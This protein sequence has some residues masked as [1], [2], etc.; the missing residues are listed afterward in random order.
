MPQ[1]TEKLPR[2][3]RL[4]RIQYKPFSPRTLPNWEGTAETHLSPDQRGRRTPRLPFPL[5]LVVRAGAECQRPTSPW[6]PKPD[7]SIHQGSPSA[8]HTLLSAHCSSSWCGVPQ[9]PP[10]LHHFG[11]RQPVRATG[12]QG[13]GPRPPQL[14]L[15][16]Q[17]TPA[18]STPDSPVCTCFSFSCPDSVFP[19]QR[20]RGPAWP[21][22]TSALAIPPKQPQRSL[23]QDPQPLEI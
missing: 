17:A 14:Q 21:T 8:T 19:A 11:S 18:H 3:T 2:L 13:S 20:A 23:P 7:P 16:C 15:P 6:Q 10:G 5:H 12:E 22:T 1:G 9:N 4:R